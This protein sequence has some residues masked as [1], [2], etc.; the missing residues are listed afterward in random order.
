VS[1]TTRTADVRTLL[2]DRHGHTATMSDI[3]ELVGLWDS[4]PFEYGSME[5]SQLALLADGSGWAVWANAAGGLELTVLEWQRLDANHFGIAEKQLISGTW[6]STRPGCVMCNESPMSVDDSAQFEYELFPQVP[7]LA[8][9]LVPVQALRLDKSF[10]FA[11]TYALIR[12][13][14]V[15]A[16]RPSVVDWCD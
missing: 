8:D 14:V 9:S 6:D 12:R 13:D 3:D 7:P 11:R 10:Q 16:D 15:E 5:A 2:A 1:R 4:Q